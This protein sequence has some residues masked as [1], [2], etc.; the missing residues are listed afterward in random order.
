MGLNKNRVTSATFVNRLFKGNF[1]TTFMKNIKSCQ[2]NQFFSIK[3]FKKFLIN[4]F[5]ASVDFSHKN[6]TF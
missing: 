5:K 2:K 6:I 3:I 1:I 4:I